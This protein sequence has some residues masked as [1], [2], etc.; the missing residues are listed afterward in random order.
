MLVAEHDVLLHDDYLLNV[1][2]SEH[3]AEQ[4]WRVNVT[5][6]AEAGTEASATVAAGES[7]LMHL[8]DR[9]VGGEEAAWRHLAAWGHDNLC[10]SVRGVRVGPVRVRG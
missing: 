5:V 6:P 2:I 8:I 3:A 4:F 1:R 10:R 9:A 7:F